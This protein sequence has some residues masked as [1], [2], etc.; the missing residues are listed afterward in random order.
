MLDDFAGALGMSLGSVAK[1]LA[2]AIFVSD[3]FFSDRARFALVK[4]PV[5]F[6]VGAIRMLGGQYVPGSNSG[7]RQDTSNILATFSRAMGEDIYNPPDVA[8]WELN[9]GYVERGELSGDV[10]HAQPRDRVARKQRG[11]A[12]LVASGVTDFRYS[13]VDSGSDHGPR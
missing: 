6:I 2:R 10:A 13:I 9:L 5:E 1:S 12:G 4:Q 3:E 8:G 7:E 11:L